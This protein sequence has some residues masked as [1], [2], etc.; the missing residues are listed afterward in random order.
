M[1]SSSTALIDSHTEPT[2]P[3]LA[4]PLRVLVSASTSP[5]ISVSRYQM[6]C[7]TGSVG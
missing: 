7:L 1:H 4:E 3:E 2:S 5:D 6:D